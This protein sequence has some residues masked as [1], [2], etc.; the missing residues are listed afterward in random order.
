M[1]HRLSLATLVLALA[2][3]PAQ[4]AGLQKVDPRTDAILAAALAECIADVKSGDATAPTPELLIEPGAITHAALDE[5]EPKDDV[6]VDFNHILCSLNYS[7]WHG[8]GGSILHIVLNGETS[9]SW[10]G[11]LRR[12]DEFN[13]LP[14]LLIGRHG[15]ACDGYGAQ[16]CVQAIS[17]FEGGFSTVRFPEANEEPQGLAR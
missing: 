14:L 1:M 3:L 15:T 12:I 9:Q 5:P 7:L 16:P 8:S 2:A 11:G 17:V 6:I 10:S 4:A 13:G